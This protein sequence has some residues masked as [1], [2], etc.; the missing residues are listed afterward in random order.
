MFSLNKF[1]KSNP[2]VKINNMVRKKYDKLNNINYNENNIYLFNQFFIHEHTERYDEIKFCLKKNIEL[3]LFTKI[4]LLNER[5]YTNQEL[6]L[7]QEEMLMI[8]Q[9]DI[10]KRLKFNDC[11]SEI[12]KLQLK[13]YFVI[14]NSDIFFDK[15]IINLRKSCLS[16]IKSMYMLLRFE[17]L[18]EK[19]LDNCKLYSDNN[20]IPQDTSQDT[21]IYHSNFK[22]DNKVINNCNF[23]FG[24]PGCDNK[25]AYVMYKSGYLLFYIY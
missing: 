21:W 5:I 20:N 7:S 25:I 22:P 23:S 19:N 18:K 11:F 2:N 14:S 12:N 13:G 24:R 8:E 6:G 16:K 3:G 4:I 10:S 17:Y 1:Y 9:I 15:T